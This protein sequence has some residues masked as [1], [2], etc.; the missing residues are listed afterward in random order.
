MSKELLSDEQVE[1]EINELLQSEYVKLAQYEK[2]IRYRRRQYLYQL[3]W[4]EKRGMVLAEEG[5]TMEHLKCADIPDDI[6]SN[7]D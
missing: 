7:A 2:R 1:A 3:R 5:I 6:L 4:Y